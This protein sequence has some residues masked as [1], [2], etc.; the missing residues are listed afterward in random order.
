MDPYARAL[1]ALALDLSGGSAANINALLGDLNDSV[2]LSAAGAHWE[3][4]LPDWNNLSSD[5]RGT[6]IILDALARLDADNLMAPNAVRWLM[7]SR[8]AGHWATNFE[9]AWSILALTD[10]MVA[11]G[12]LEAEFTYQIA[13]NGEQITDSEFDQSNITQAEQLTV[14]VN[15][16]LADEVN[17][18]DFQRSTGDGRLYYTAY[19]NSFISA[20]NLPAI[21]RGVI[22]QRAYYSADCDPEETEC[23]P[24]TSI[25]AG[26]T[27]RVE[28][29]IIVPNDLVYATIEHHFPAGAEAIDPNLETSASGQGGS[30]EQVTDNPYRYG[31]WG[32]WYFTNIEYRDDRVVFLTDF[33]PA[34][35][36]QYSYTLQTTIPG[37]YQVL[38]AVA[39]QEF[40]PDIFGRSEGFIFTI[41]E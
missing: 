21:N 2:I 9:T 39:Y 34:G 32:W 15:D 20:E 13:V 40:F 26:E 28:L 30:V 35:T 6:A 19:L 31:Y 12:E 18:L 24:I 8:T 16:L 27:V 29:T 36:Y 1:L 7:S 11:S 4:E 17:F 22:V 14:P 37:Q 5:I 23:E 25:A 3:D 10:W 38:P 41:E 33:L